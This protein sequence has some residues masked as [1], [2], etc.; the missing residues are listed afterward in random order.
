MI[1]LT[2]ALHQQMMVDLQRPH[3]FALERVGF[4][5]GALGTGES[6]QF[7]LAKRYSPVADEHYV[8]APDVG[9]MINDQAIRAAREQSLCSGDGV[10]HVHLHHSRG[11]PRFSR[12]DLDG[13]RVMVPA[14]RPM[15]A[16]APHGALLLSLDNA[17]G[18]VIWP[19][20]E[21]MRPSPVR[22]VGFPMGVWGGYGHT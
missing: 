1:R 10:F 11:V 3:P 13:Y 15:A 16:K 5:F 18:L 8:D 22:L 12:I 14:F 4:L 20:E 19:S 6:G 9:A 2:H 17:T 21:A 7:V